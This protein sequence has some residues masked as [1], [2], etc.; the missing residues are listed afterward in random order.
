MTTLQVKTEIKKILNNIPDG[1]LPG[2]LDYLK[3]VQTQS[4]E[5]IKF[6]N[7]VKK[8]LSEDKELFKRLAK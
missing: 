2:I 7:N 3:L 6:N 1:I 4:P 5:Q 8:I